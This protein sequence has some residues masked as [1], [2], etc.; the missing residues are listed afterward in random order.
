[1]HYFGWFIS[2]LCRKATA[3]FI[4]LPMM[5]ALAPFTL[6]GNALGVAYNRLRSR[7]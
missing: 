1:M 7:R 2:R 6:A 3:Y 5:A 4:V